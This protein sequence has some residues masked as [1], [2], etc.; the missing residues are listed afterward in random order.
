MSEGMHLYMSWQICQNG[1]QANILGILG[2]HNSILM[3][4]YC[5]WTVGGCMWK[6]AAINMDQQQVRHQIKSPVSCHLSLRV[7]GQSQTQTTANYRTPLL[8]KCILI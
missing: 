4:I 7:G 3:D 5:I 2:I 8:C 1:E 6:A